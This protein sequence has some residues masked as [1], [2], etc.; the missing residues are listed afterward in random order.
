MDGPTAGEF[1]ACPEAAGDPRSITQKIPITGARRHTT[2][3]NS[4]QRGC[5]P[6]LPS[7]LD[8]GALNVGALGLINRFVPA[9]LIMFASTNML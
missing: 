7:T 3:S 8:V 6:A 1:G 9:E 4:L 5:C 2:R